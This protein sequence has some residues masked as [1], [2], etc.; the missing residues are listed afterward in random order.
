[1]FSYI[2][3]NHIS[4][5]LKMACNK[6]DTGNSTSTALPGGG[7][8]TGE[9]IDVLDYNTFSVIYESDVAGVTDSLRIQFS[10]DG[11][12]VIR[13]KLVTPQL[14]QDGSGNYGGVHVL[15]IVSQYLRI[16]Y[17]NGLDPQSTFDLQTILSL[18]SE[19][20]LTSTSEQTI[21]KEDDVLLT[22]SLIMGKTSGGLYD[23]V[24]ISPIDKALQVEV[25][26]PTSAFGELE[27]VNPSPIVQADFI[28]NINLDI[29]NTSTT[30]GTV[31]YSE[32]Q[33]VVSSSA[34]TSSHAEVSTKRRVKYR[35]GQGS[36]VRLTA[37]FTQGVNGNTQ[38]A[39]CFDDDNGLGFGYN[40]TSFGVFKTSGSVTE[41]ISQS[42]WNSDLMDGSKTA[43]NPSGALL[44]K[45]KGNVYQIKYQW[46]G[47]GKLSFFIEDSGTGDFVM[48]HSIKYANNNTVPSLRN[49]SFPIAW[50]SENTTNNTDITI[51]GASCVGEV[52]GKVVYLG[53]ENSV[54]NSKTNVG[55]SFTNILT[56]RNKSTFASQDNKTPCFIR[57]YTIAVDGTKPAEFELV[58]NA[59]IGGT[60][61]FTDVS[62]NTSLID[63]DTAGTTV[64][65]GIN[66][67][68]IALSKDGATNVTIENGDLDIE[69]GDTITLAVRST[70]STTDVSVS[71]KWVEDF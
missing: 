59:T 15:R 3:Q 5:L 69:P 55:S 1:M 10:V 35:P 2:Y 57:K 17:D 49:P 13:E 54:P 7:A 16:I 39:G 29:F 53:P 63:Y 64:T 36:H 22:R 18:S 4:Q 68:T 47:Y 58:K 30:N 28:Y 60:P 43:S 25:V 24:S 71:I 6:L 66:L 70:S 19:R 56:I 40:G 67:D 46:L 52:E 45:E 62:T 42:S 41:W 8:F 32:S 48:V 44:D 65:G 21:T 26:G 61:S 31:T 38:K 20:G 9:W 12:N 23:N 27:I 33:A 34:N 37:L 14:Q 50:R 51:K 11:S